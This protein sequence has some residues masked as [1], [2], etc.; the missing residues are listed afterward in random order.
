MFDYEN[1]WNKALKR[2][3]YDSDLA[4]IQGANRVIYLVRELKIP[5]QL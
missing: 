3:T 5:I 2:E 4:F 1:K